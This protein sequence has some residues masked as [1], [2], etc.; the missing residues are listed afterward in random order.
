MENEDLAIIGSA[1]VAMARWVPC[2]ATLCVFITVL[3]CQ[4][5]IAVDRMMGRYVPLWD[6]WWVSIYCVGL[7]GRSN[8]FVISGLKWE[9][10]ID[11]FTQPAVKITTLTWWKTCNSRNI[12]LILYIYLPNLRL[13]IK[14]CCCEKIVDHNTLLF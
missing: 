4:P 6:L 13:I 8:V 10:S 12:L 11:Y 5:K 7:D 9:W 3:R 2:Y 14:H 1:L